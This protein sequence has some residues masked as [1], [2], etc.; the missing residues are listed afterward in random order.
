MSKETRPIHTQKKTPTGSLPVEPIWSIA[1]GFERLGI[2]S[3]ALQGALLHLAKGLEV[4]MRVR[5]WTSIH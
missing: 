1:S 4:K 5:K 3:A 2:S